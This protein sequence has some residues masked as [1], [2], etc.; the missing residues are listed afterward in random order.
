MF[1]VAPNSPCS[2]VLGGE[3]RLFD[4]SVNA[5]A[6]FQYVAMAKNTGNAQLDRLVIMPSWDM[7]PVQ[8]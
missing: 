2:Y 7:N 8:F 6:P 5:H 1:R 4:I 3:R